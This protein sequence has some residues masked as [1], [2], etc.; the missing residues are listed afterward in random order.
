MGSGSEIQ[1]QMDSNVAI[2]TTGWLL[3]SLPIGSWKQVLEELASP[4]VVVQVM[5]SVSLQLY[6]ENTHL[7]S[8][9]KATLQKLQK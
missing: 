7:M 5:H 9:P 6:A 2:P 8:P 3:L 1:V 4:M